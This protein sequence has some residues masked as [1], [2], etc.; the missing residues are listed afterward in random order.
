MG[1]GMDGSS[2]WHY[3]LA[4]NGFMVTTRKTL[5]LV[6]SLPLPS[7]SVPYNSYFFVCYCT[8]LNGTLL[9]EKTLFFCRTLIFFIVLLHTND[10]RER[11]CVSLWLSFLHC[12]LEISPSN[13]LPSGSKHG[14][15]YIP[16]TRFSHHFCW[17]YDPIFFSSLYFIIFFYRK[18]HC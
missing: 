11:V 2:S 1:T 14:H 18:H 8:Q 17:C 9:G 13:I 15:M 12:E 5:V 10:A 4:K 3:G 6:Y 16:H 7:H